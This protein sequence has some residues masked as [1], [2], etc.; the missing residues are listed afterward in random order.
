ME[1]R[2]L[3]SLPL[4]DGTFQISIF[5]T[6]PKDHALYRDACAAILKNR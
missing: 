2:P 1:S 3:E 4:M 6:Q 5:D